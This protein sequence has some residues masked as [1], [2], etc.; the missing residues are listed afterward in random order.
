M[1]LKVK[2][3]RVTG[4]SD[5]AEIINEWLA[6]ND[7]IEI[8]SINHA[9][10]VSDNKAMMVSI[11]VWYREPNKEATL[12]DTPEVRA[13]ASGRRWFGLSKP[14]PAEKKHYDPDDQL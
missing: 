10:A 11:S 4:L 6:A 2:F 12:T 3:F 7:G 1:A 5:S 9:A 14:S 13:S 8:V